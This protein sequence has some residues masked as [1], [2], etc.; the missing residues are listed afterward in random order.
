MAATAEPGDESPQRAGKWLAVTRIAIGFVF[1]W[2]FLDKT[3]GLGYST[4]SA[5]SWLKGGSPTAGFLG[6]VSVG[7]FE[8]MF[9]G[10]AGS[11]FLDWLFMLGLL[12]IGLAVIAGI[13]LRLS[14]VLGSIMMLMMWA[15]EW[16]LAM[17]TSAGQP[18][19]STNPLVDYHI[20]YVLVLIVVAVGSAGRTWG[21][22]ST[23]ARLP[24]VQRYRWLI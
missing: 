7:P 16:P 23:W 9:K 24:I 12:A 5:R 4:V 8:S 13:G 11:G 22:G 19:G 6:H 20:I 3:L 15:A 14:A 1:L 21:L 10:W 2:A 17:T 18:S